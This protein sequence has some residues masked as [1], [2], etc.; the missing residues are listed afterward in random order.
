MLT[1]KEVKQCLENQYLVACQIVGVKPQ[2]NAVKLMGRKKRYPSLKSGYYVQLQ[3]FDSL[4]DAKFF[5]TDDHVRYY[6][7][8]LQFSTRRFPLFE[9]GKWMPSNGTVEQDKTIF[10][11]DEDARNKGDFLEHFAT[12]IYWCHYRL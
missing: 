8:C 9:I 4:K 5:K 6:V 7:R 2:P 12:L 3:N 10:R 11:S 1:D